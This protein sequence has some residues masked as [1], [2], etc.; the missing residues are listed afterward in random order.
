MLFSDPKSKKAA[1]EN[2]PEAEKEKVRTTVYLMDRFGISMESYH[3]LS[4]INSGMAR[5][6]LVESCMRSCDSRWSDLLTRTPGENEGA[7]LPFEEILREEIR[8]QV[9]FGF[10]V[11]LGQSVKTFAF[12][13]QYART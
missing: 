3:E 13:C 1:F 2:L 4:Q 10:T 12:C 6:Y 8:K 11:L 9:S 5:S 7:Q